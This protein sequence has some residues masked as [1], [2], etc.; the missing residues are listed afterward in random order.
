MPTPPAYLNASF[1]RFQPSQAHVSSTRRS[2]APSNSSTRRSKKGKNAN[3]DS[4]D[5]GI[6]KFKKEFERFHSENGVRTVMGSIGPVQNG[7]LGFKCTCM[8]RP[9]TFPIYSSN[10]PQIRI[11]ARLYF[12]QIRHQAWVHPS[13]RSSRKLWLWR[14]CKYRFMANYTYAFIFSAQSPCCRSSGCLSPSFSDAFTYPI[15]VSSYT[16]SF[17]FSTPADDGSTRKNEE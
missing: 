15:F 2:P 1:Y 12:P 8:S 10:A 11:P 5:D 17:F 6:P 3:D 9:L 16:C 4:E 13:R 14:T 7:S